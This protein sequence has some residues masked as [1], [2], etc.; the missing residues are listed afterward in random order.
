MNI[1]ALDLATVT[2]W[3]LLA[4]KDSPGERISSGTQSFAINARI[5]GAGM[6]YLRFERWLDEMHRMYPIHR[7]A[8]EEVKQRAQSV[9]AGHMYGGF[10]ATL[11][12]WCEA[13]A[14]PYEGIPVGTI[15]K[16]WTGAGNSGK[17][18]MVKVARERGFD[19]KDDNEADA[20]ALLHYVSTYATTSP[21]SVRPAPDRKPQGRVPV[22]PVHLPRR[23]VSR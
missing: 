8:F 9:A 20:L 10:M 7:L 2:G 5:E 3:A 14:V 1:L 13:G 4:N 17:D 23:P 22:E 15:K 18:I 16:F 6:R 21:P 19:P 11:T 12:K